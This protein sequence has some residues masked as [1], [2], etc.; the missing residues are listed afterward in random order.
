MVFWKSIGQSLVLLVVFLA[1]LAQDVECK[2]C[3]ECDSEY[4][5]C[6]AAST[7]VKEAEQCIQSKKLCKQT[8]ITPTVGIKRRWNMLKMAAATNKLSR[9]YNKNNWNAEL[10]K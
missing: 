8:C 7:N 3:H 9:R 6:H 10:E 4:Y 5:T 1:F 2:S